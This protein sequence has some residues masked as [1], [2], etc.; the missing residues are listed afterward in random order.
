MWLVRRLHLE[1]RTV[2][3]WPGEHRQIKTSTARRVVP[4]PSQ[5]VEIL[6]PYVLGD[7]PRIG[8]LFP[9]PETGKMIT[10]T[11]WLLDRLAKRIGL[12]GGGAVTRTPTHLLRRRAPDDG[13]G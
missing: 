13:P 9:S 5:I 1:R 10:D 11:R 12:E 7:E 8:L 6:P 4:M 2:V 3:F